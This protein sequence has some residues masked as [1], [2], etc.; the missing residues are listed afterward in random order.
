MAADAAAMTLTQSILTYEWALDGIILN[1][2]QQE[3]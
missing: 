1:E 2:Q 3:A